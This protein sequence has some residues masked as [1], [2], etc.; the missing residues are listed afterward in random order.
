MIDWFRSWHGAPTDNKWLLIARKAGSKPGVVS[1]VAW[2]L[3]DH[4]SQAA[5][6]GNVTG[7]D[8]ETYA[9]FSGFDEAEVAAIIAALKDKGLILADGMLA[10]WDK[11]QPSREDTGAAQ[12]MRAYRERQKRTVT[13]RYADVTDGDASDTTDK[14]RV[15][16]KENAPNKKGAFLSAGKTSETAS[17]A[18]WVERD[19]DA[20][21]AWTQARGGK[22]LILSRDAPDGMQG[23]WCRSE[24]PPEIQA[25]RVA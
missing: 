20:W 12:R 24:Y 3:M 14:N 8:A 4:A 5:T 1:A 22:E 9:A 17:G 7:F 13:Q 25:V 16:Q 2:A 21:K 19:S 6:R 23:Q 11:R 18:V 10:S 15:E